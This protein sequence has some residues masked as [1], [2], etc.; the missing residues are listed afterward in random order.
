MTQKEKDQIKKLAQLDNILAS[1]K[2]LERNQC[3]MRGFILYTPSFKEDIKMV[4]FHICLVHETRTGLTLQKFACFSQA[5]S[6]I[7]TLKELNRVAYVY[8]FGH[9]REIK[10]DTKPMITKLSIAKQTNLVLIA[11]GKDY[12]K[13]GNKE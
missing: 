5:T 10:G 1:A 2:Q 13:K 6:V 9:I 8:A 11:K 12:G 3:Y 4:A 7:K